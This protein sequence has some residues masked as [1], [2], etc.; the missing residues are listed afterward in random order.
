MRIFRPASNRT[1]DFASMSV[2]LW[3]TPPCTSCGNEVVSQIYEYSLLLAMKGTKYVLLGVR[4]AAEF[5]IVC[6]CTVVGASNIQR[7][8]S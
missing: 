7:S 4:R 3:T 8:R 1:F 6:K 5:S 2:S